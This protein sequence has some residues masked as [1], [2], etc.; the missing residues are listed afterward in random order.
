MYATQTNYQMLKKIMDKLIDK[1]FVEESVFGRNTRSTHPNGIFYKLTR[2]GTI[3]VN[4]SRSVF[5]QLE[6]LQ[7]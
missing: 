1:E 7:S 5:Q 3:F 4:T 2:K 6:E